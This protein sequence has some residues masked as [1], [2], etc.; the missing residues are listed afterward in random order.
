MPE[1]D[2]SGSDDTDGND[3]KESKENQNRASLNNNPSQ[4]PGVESQENCLINSEVQGSG[5]S[6]GP[7]KLRGS[8]P[9]I[10][11]PFPTTT[12]N[13]NSDGNSLLSEQLEPQPVNEQI[14]AEQ[15]RTSFSAESA[16][17]DDLSSHES[18][19]DVDTSLDNLAPSEDRISD[20]SCKDC[21]EETSELP[22]HLQQQSTFN[23]DGTST[24][25]I[26]HYATV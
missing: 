20:E 25:V 3:I 22:Y 26:F 8:T 6:A 24:E 23:S 21:E 9:E 14:P 17:D 16:Q 5:T 7:L 15:N 13:T 18:A 11:Q 1:T 19:P 10:P 12:E 4:R 2:T